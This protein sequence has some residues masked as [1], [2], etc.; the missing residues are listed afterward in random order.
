M[1][2]TIDKTSLFAYG[3]TLASLI[4]IS[5]LSFF[6]TFNILDVTKQVLRAYMVNSALEQIRSSVVDMES[7]ERGYLAT[8]D[9]QLEQ[10][11]E[12]ARQR[13]SIALRQAADVSGDPEQAQSLKL[14]HSDVERR[15]DQFDQLDDMAAKG[16]FDAALKIVRTGDGEVLTTEIKKT[17]THMQSVENRGL[18]QALRSLNLV[19]EETLRF[20]LF[21]TIISIAV[22]LLSFLF[23]SNQ[24]RMRQMKE[25]SER[26]Q[27]EALNAMLTTIGD[28]VI[29]VERNDVRIFNP[30]AAML[31]GKGPPPVPLERWSEVY[32]F[33]LLDKRTALPLAENPIWRALN[34]EN[35]DQMEL[36]VYNDATPRGRFISITART[37][38]DEAGAP[39]AAVAVLH[40]ITQRKVGEQRL[41]EF[42]A[43]LSHE[44]RTPLTSIRGSMGLLEAGVAG[45]LSEMA[46]ELVTI[47]KH[48][49]DRLVRLVNNIL[50]LKKIEAGKLQLHTAAVAPTSIVKTTLT[51]LGSLA[52]E[53]NV[54]L[55]EVITTE[56]MVLCD[57]DRIIQVLTNLVANAIKFSPEGKAIEIKV[58]EENP[59]V[60]FA[61]VDRGPGIAADHL[62][63]LFAKYQQIESAQRKGTGL[64]LAI[65]KALVEQHGGKIGVES[66]IG[67]GS[68]FW[69][70]IPVGDGGK[71]E[72]Q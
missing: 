55:I 26:R 63:L 22:L 43:L 70:E 5:A 29:I 10:P 72:G 16:Q 35:I 14:L 53:T 40:D 33:F 58:S 2:L 64:G 11:Y 20:C 3:L 21:A 36:Y 56:R 51:A 62:P 8:H 6:H 1:K 47:A 71:S 42:Y 27:K 37:L 17:V 23:V 19:N 12:S 30:A 28:G 69:F 7:A 32:G 68:T 24:L 46:A 4:A 44:L 65:S 50:D 49:V 54:A 41:N 61:V 31:L 66:R 59:H 52:A 45:K 38:H 18:Y 15:V 25:E 34:G 39:R 48:E 60:R 13:L 9:R 67:E 57:Q